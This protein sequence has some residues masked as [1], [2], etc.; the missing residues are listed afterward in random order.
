MTEWI[1]LGWLIVSVAIAVRVYGAPRN[2][3]PLGQ[4]KTDFPILWLAV[5]VFP[6]HILVDVLG[7]GLTMIREAWNHGRER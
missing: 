3:D 6:A 7:K 5:F 1:L 4:H 2:R